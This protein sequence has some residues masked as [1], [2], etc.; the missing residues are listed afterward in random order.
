M[1]FNNESSENPKV[2]ANIFASNFEKVYAPPNNNLQLPDLQCNCA[3]HL[4]ISDEQIINAINE[5][6]ENTNSPDEIPTVFYKR[7]M[8]NIIHP[9]KIL[10][11]NSL[12]NR[13]FPDKLKLS[14][15]TPL[16]KNGD[17]SNIINYRPISIISAISKIFEKIM[18]A[19]IY[20]S[21]TNSITPHQHGF[22]KSKSTISNLAEY[23]SYLSTNMAK[24]VDRLIQ[25][26]RISKRL[27]ICLITPFL[28][29]N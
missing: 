29:K 5:L 24:K 12:H 4:N 1:K 23:V 17:K 7:T 14:F 8:R 9:L 15:I 25:F 27:L 3:H 28:S 11:S 6:S 10:F 21:V 16:H 22:T 2:I 18:Y 19:H 20:G 13:T 26:P